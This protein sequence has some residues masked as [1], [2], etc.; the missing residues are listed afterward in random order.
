L[1]NHD[2]LTSNLEQLLETLIRMVGR[3]NQNVENLQ[4]RVTQLE[5][6]MKEQQRT[7]TQFILQKS[8]DR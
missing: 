4:K 5:L 8:A 2:D 6:T 3:A 7:R 1:G